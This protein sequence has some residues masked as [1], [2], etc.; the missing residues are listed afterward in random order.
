[1]KKF[2]FFSIFFLS[3]LTS[4]IVPLSAENSFP[5]PSQKSLAKEEAIQKEFNCIDQRMGQQQNLDWDTVCYMD[6]EVKLAQA[7][8][9]VISNALNREQRRQMKN[10][11]ES[12]DKKEKAPVP[13]PPAKEVPEPQMREP[14]EAQEKERSLEVGGDIYHFSYK[15][16]IF[17]LED[18][19]IMYGT[20]AIY[21][22]HPSEDDGLNFG[23]IDVYQAEGRLSYGKVD[24]SSS[25][26]GTLEN[27]P[28]YTFELRML[29][30]KDYYWDE[31]SRVRPYVGFG[32][33]YLN[34]DTG[35]K[36]SSTG[37]S[38][39]ERES[40]YYYLPI[41]GEF[42]HLFNG[43]WEIEVQGEYDVFLQGTQVS[44]LTD[45]DGGLPDLKNE[46]H[47]GL[48]ARGS[49]KLTKKTEQVNYFVEPFIRYWHID[50]SEVNTAAGYLYLLTGYEPENTST[51]IG[52]RVGVEF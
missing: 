39:Y 11:P 46:Q 22:V 10:S 4:G 50:D 30:G 23:I 40:R 51:E 36:L 29:A 49:V 13:K 19:G 43:G 42:K 1:M 28:D 21:T 38:G 6:D 44:K 37:A 7:R 9:K 35:G 25:G 31:Y 27:I 14:L 33:R 2:L 5:V 48:G 41:G 3:F 17:D 34:D 15:E 24:Y 32:F 16:P 8:E 12:P 18:K 20:Y 52:A 45:V 26:S 47:S